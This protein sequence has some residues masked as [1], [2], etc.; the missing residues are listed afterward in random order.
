MN[1]Q[2]TNTPV[3]RSR[4]PVP[5]MPAGPKVTVHKPV[6]LYQPRETST[7]GDKNA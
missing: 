3:D 2:P 4:S 6:P 7:E 1:T 5:P